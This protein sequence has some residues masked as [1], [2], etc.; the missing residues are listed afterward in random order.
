LKAVQSA[1][2]IS[3][4]NIGLKKCSFISTSMIIGFLCPVILLPEKNFDADE[5][6]LIFRHELIHYKRGDLFV[7]LLSIIATSIHWFNP[8][9]YLMNAAMQADC[10]ASCDEAVLSDIGEN[11][12]QYYAELIMDMIGRKSNNRTALS[13]CFY[14]GKR[15][16]QTRMNAI[17][18]ATG[19]IKKVSF[20]VLLT[21]VVLMAL[22]VSVF[23]FSGS[24][25]QE[26]APQ[27]PYEPNVTET[28][29]PEPPLELPPEPNPEPTPEPAGPIT[30]Q[31]A[32]DIAYEFLAAQGINATFLEDSG[33]E[34]EYG[35]LVW[36]LLFRA[37]GERMPYIEF[38]IN[39]ENG[40][41][42]KF[43]WDD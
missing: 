22:S 37:H 28:R 16:I 21:L 34:W 12:N 32:I 43:E 7:K 27:E 10:E 30:R 23:A 38:Y 3:S 25:I 31:R 24:S 20:S 39:A 41:I 19:G 15:G 33:M 40:N 8:A 6:E 11:N 35:Q 26:P 2:G 42:V 1:K 13:T 36:E 9:V 29:P 4:K 17:M 5:L 18:S 14:G